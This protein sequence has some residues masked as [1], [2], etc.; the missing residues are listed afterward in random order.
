MS[1]FSAHKS[2]QNML[3]RHVHI[4]TYYMHE[5]CTHPI[6][7]IFINHAHILSSE[8]FICHSHH[9]ECIIFILD[10][11]YHHWGSNS[12]TPKMMFSPGLE[13]MGHGARIKVL[14]LLFHATYVIKNI[15][16]KGSKLFHTFFLSV[17]PFNV[18]F[19]TFLTVSSFQ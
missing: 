10:V 16:F 6:A 14:T 15:Y 1:M 7:M 5:S 8:L 18:V 12:Q 19:D 17:I 3:I 11:Y 4:Y 2:S 9:C 13:P